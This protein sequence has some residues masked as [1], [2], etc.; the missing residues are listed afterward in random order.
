MKPDAPASVADSRSF[1]KRYTMVTSERRSYM[2][3]L[4][5][6][7]VIINAVVGIFRR[8]F[9]G[10]LGRTGGVAFYVT[11]YPAIISASIT[12]VGGIAIALSS[13][14]GLLIF[15]GLVIIFTG[16]WLGALG[17]AHAIRKQ[18][19]LSI[20]EWPAILSALVVIGGNLMMAIGLLDNRF[21]FVGFIILGVGYRI[22]AF[23]FY[24]VINAPAY[25]TKR[26]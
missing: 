12:L 14:D 1:A 11:G 26:Q 24:P 7:V 15:A 22:G 23:F 9:G 4:I 20:S 13:I 21:F 10:Q 18:K 17:Y 2:H 25:N 3:I 5:A 19:M 16:Y 8:R 6:F